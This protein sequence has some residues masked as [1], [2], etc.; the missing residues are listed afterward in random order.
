MK[1]KNMCLKP[2]TYDSSN[3]ALAACAGRLTKLT[4]FQMMITFARR[5]ERNAIQVLVG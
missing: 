2:R 1:E 4:L 3:C 5:D